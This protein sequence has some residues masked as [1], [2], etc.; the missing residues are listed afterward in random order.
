M[1]KTTL[2][3]INLLLLLGLVSKAANPYDWQGG[4]NYSKVPS[5]YPGDDV[6]VTFKPDDFFTFLWPEKWSEKY[7]LSFVLVAV[8]DGQTAEEALLGNAPIVQEKDIRSYYI[9][10]PC[11]APPLK[12]GEYAWQIE[13]ADGKVLLTTKFNIGDVNTSGYEVSS[14]ENVWMYTKEKLDGSYQVAYDRVLRVHVSEPYAVDSLQRLRFC[15][16][17]SQ[18]RLV[19]KTD[20]SG[21][22]IDYDVHPISSPIITTGENWLT[23]P[24]GNNC[25]YDDY[26][27]LEVWDTKGEKSFLRLQCIPSTPK[28]IP[29]PK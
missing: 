5:Y 11:D 20:D 9:Q 15:V 19:L 13:T 10:Y 28:L 21:T 23:I 14:P 18:R 8:K 22:V 1:N 12:F 17:D 3:T 26:Y 7:S 24:L 6:T 29:S 4:V 25:T 2:L 16:Y 27:Y